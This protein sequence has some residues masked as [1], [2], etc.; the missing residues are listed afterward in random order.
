MQL[1]L[2]V[3]VFM[4]VQAVLFGVGAVAILA[5]PLAEY[6]EDLMAPM[7]I[8]TTLVSIPIAWR[9]AVKMRL[10]NLRVQHLW[11]HVSHSRAR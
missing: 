5:T 6:A 11:R 8:V 3:L 10:N 4:M 7:I 2:S 9:I 1:F